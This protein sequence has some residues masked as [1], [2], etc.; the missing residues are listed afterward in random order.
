MLHSLD[1]I[2][3]YKQGNLS[4]LKNNHWLR[5]L[6]LTQESNIN[7]ERVDSI[8]ELKKNLVL[9]YVG[10]T[11]SI[12]DSLSLPKR[13]SNIIEEVLVWSEVAKCGLRHQREQWIQ[14]GYNLFVHNIGSAQIYQDE[15][16]HHENH[17]DKDVI[18][19]LI[20]T[21]GLI[22]QYIRGEVPLQFNQLLTELVKKETMDGNEF[23]SILRALNQAIIAGVS[24]ELWDNVKDEAN[25]VIQTIIHGEYD[26]TI[27]FAE[28]LKRLRSLSIRNGENFEQEYAKSMSPDGVLPILKLVFANCDFWFVEAALYDFNFEKF[29]KILLLICTCAQE[30]DG[31]KIKHI[32]FERLMKGL[33]YQHEGQKKI[34]IYK[35][36][37][38]EKY[39]DNYTIPEIMAG[40]RKTNPHVEHRVETSRELDDTVFFD[41]QFSPA[42]EKLIDFCNEA[43]K[44]DLL[45]ERAIILLFDLFELRRD[46]YDRFYEEDKYLVT[47][48]NGVDY[49]K[50]ILDYICGD[51][52]LDVGPGG[53]VLLDL[54]EGKF[55]QKKVTGI[56]ISQNVI[57]ALQRKKQSEQKK[58]QVIYGD[59]LNLA[60]CLAAESVNT[61]IFCSIIHE[62]YSYIEYERNKFNYKTIACV[63]KSAFDVLAP[64]GRI[65]IRDGIMTE[66]V[67]QRRMIRFLSDDGLKFL[68]RYAADFQGRKIEYRVIDHNQ[69]IMPVNDAMEFLYTYT[70]GEQ[71]YAHEIN[72]QFGYFTPAEYVSFIQENLGHDAQVIECRHFLQ[73]GYSTALAHKIEFFDENQKPIPLPDSTCLI[74]IQKRF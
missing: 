36:R 22:G 70:W 26:M 55:P 13:Q 54:I 42:G 33:Y 7:M 21:H 28:R 51:R 61:V 62:L 37:V 47:M 34:N 39:L 11:L 52:I 65:I 63:L 48:N 1:L 30:I 66:P 19:A 40:V 64:G 20:R 35:K 4:V 71:S 24:P 69:V 49:K 74:V 60:G 68:A 50:I 2:A 67:A 27:G 43:E 53:G 56:D 18:V 6:A 45:Y 15:A 23:H 72:E 16:E 17:P 3:A 44:A 25:S 5:Y 58:W 38:I 12:L 14:K 29:I 41:F 32:S 8:A 31:N 9:D 46:P 59:A 73:E 10:R 57:E